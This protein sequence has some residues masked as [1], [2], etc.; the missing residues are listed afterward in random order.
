MI[1][2]KKNKEKWFKKKIMSKNIREPII[3]A[4]NLLSL[5]FKD[6]MRVEGG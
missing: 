2:Q 3:R 1:W 5:S 4:K 6:G